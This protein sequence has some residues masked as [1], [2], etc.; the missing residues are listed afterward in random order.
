MRSQEAALRKASNGNYDWGISS[1]KVSNDDKQQAAILLTEQLIATLSQGGQVRDVSVQ[2]LQGVSNRPP[3]QTR[4]IGAAYALRGDVETTLRVDEVRFQKSGLGG[5]R[6]VF[7]KPSY[8]VAKR[9]PGEAYVQAAVQ[10]LAWRYCWA[11]VVCVV[12][13]NHTARWLDVAS[14]LHVRL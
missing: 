11:V 13:R 9:G 1:G 12:R 6:Y 14:A 5:G 4:N 2:L 7:D 8:A 3:V 10:V